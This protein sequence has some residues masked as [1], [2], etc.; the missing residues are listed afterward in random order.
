LVLVDQKLTSGGSDHMSFMKRNIP[1]LFFHSGL[2]K[3]YHTVNDRPELIDTRKVARTAG[4][5]FLT[6]WHIANDSTRYRYIP[7]TVPMF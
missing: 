2:E 7:S 6:A 1:D 4:L 5:V 3:V